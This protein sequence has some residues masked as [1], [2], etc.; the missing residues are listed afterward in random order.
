VLTVKLNGQWMAGTSRT[1]GSPTTGKD[2]AR[3]DSAGRHFMVSNI[4]HVAP[5]CST[6]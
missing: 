5:T 2:T 1:S 6:R 4:E 3:T